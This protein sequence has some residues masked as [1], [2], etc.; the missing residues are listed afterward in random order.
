MIKPFAEQYCGNTFVTCPGSNQP[1]QPAETETPIIKDNIRL[2]DLVRQARLWLH[3]QELI[4]DDEYVD[5]AT[6]GSGS[7]RRLE[8]YDDIRSKLTS[9]LAREKELREENARL[10]NLAHRIYDQLGDDDVWGRTTAGGSAEL[11][12]IQDELERCKPA[13]TKPT[14]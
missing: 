11:D 2:L 3:K 6:I 13:L 8:D 12:Y 4:T 7:A 5:L 1:V 10:A 14:P 9:A